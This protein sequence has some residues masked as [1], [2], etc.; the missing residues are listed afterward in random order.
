MA[1]TRSSNTTYTE[2]YLRKDTFYCAKSN[3]LFSQGTKHNI[4]AAKYKN[5][6][7]MCLSL[8]NT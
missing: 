6:I 7:F 8:Y 1:L 2:T 4:I 3:S 5:Y